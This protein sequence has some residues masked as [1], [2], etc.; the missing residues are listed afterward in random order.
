MTKQKETPTEGTEGVTNEI[1]GANSR[2][3]YNTNEAI[4]ASLSSEKQS[5]ILARDARERGAAEQESGRY[6]P[7]PLTQLLARD[8]PPL[9]F[10]VE[11]IL[12]KGHLAMLGGRPKSG[13]SW[14]VLQMAQAIDLGLPFLGRN[15]RKA[16]V[17]YV[18]LEDGERRL[19]QRCKITKWQPSPQA[20]VM[21]AIANFDGK[22]GTGAGI[23][24]IRE[25]APNYDLI[26]V[27][28]LIATL[29]GHADENNNTQMGGIVNELAQIAHDTDTAIVL[30]H[31][32]KKG[33]GDDVFSTF[34]G[35][36]ALRGAYDV[37]LLLERK[38]NER[39]AILHLESRDL[40]MEPLTLCQSANSAGW[41]CLG[42]GEVI[43]RV[44]AGR[45]VV[46]VM[47]KEGDGLTTEELATALS[48]SRQ[49][50]GQQLRNAERDRL[51][52]R[53]SQPKEGS[54]KPVDVWY[55]A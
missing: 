5:E 53:E 38:N 31:H 39:E 54:L 17:L 27:D 40:E 35:A 48:V 24:T 10:L 25:L 2:E 51:V 47:Q 33:G 6:A 37:G 43:Q 22:D 8:F 41:E 55:L 50:A 15:T 14:L 49:A 36:S 23:S 21:T 26:V 12:A 44:R 20:G 13:K 46:E 4:F 7:M 42:N 30:V 16:S 34:R 18:A 9:E 3:N 45:R 32:T 19:S 11:G 29:S 52:R 1:D 28:T